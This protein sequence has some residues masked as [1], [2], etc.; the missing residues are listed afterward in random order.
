MM[1]GRTYSAGNGYRYG[2]NGKENDNEVKGEGNQQDYGM[3]IYDTRIARFLSVDPLTKDFPHYTPYQFAGNKPIWALDLD[4]AE[5]WYYYNNLFGWKASQIFT[6][7][8]DQ[9]N[10]NSLGYLSAAQ[11]H[12]IVTVQNRIK[13]REEN[14]KTLNAAIE[15]KN[16]I[17]SLSNPFVLAYEISPFSSIQPVK[18]AFE[19]G[20]NVEA[21]ILS[22]AAIT[23]VGPLFK[24]FGKGYSKV[25]TEIAGKFTLHAIWGI[26]NNFVRGALMEAKL[27]GK[28]VSQSLEWMAELSPFFKTFDFY[29]RAKGLAISLKSVNAKEN[30]TFKNITENIDELAKLKGQSRAHSGQEFKVKDVRLDIAVP[31]GYDQSVLNTIKA[32]AD[33]KLGKGKINIF[34]TD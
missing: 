34:E 28:Y 8:M 17:N 13:Q 12:Q 23:D 21:T 5:E 19:E 33:E 16:K 2:F 24:T 4:G 1:P 25:A 26:E 3:R 10:A 32:Y 11:V 15:A 27:A 6:G 30:F 31:K 9:A 14:F 29:D 20:S 7:P 18:Q 22:L